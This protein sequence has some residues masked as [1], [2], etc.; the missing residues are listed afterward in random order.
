[1]KV[2][3][4]TPSFNRADILHQTAESIFKQTY[5][6]WEWVVTDDGSTDDTWKLLEQYAAAD[7]RVRIFKRNRGP[8][9]AC[10]CRNISVENATGEYLVFLDSDD[11]IASFCLEQRVSAMQAAPECD[12]IIFPMLMFRYEPGD[13][14]MLWNIDSPQDD[15]ERILLN[16]AVCQGT[17]TL[18]KKSSFVTIG[19]WNEQLLLWQ[20]VELHLRS[21]LQ[22]LKYKKRFDLK[23]DTFLRIS[24]ISISRTG[25]H[26]H[27]KFL[28]RLQVFRQTA[29][30]MQEKNLLQQYKP[31]LRSMF[32]DLFTNAANQRFENEIQP[33]LA[34][35]QQFGL[36][37]NQEVQ[38][39]KRYAWIRKGKLYRLPLLQRLI[40]ARIHTLSPSAAPT[41]NK[42]SYKGNI[43]F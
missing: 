4:I 43:A 12:F 6:D 9:G 33:V 27:P 25:Y 22:P 17:G 20:D 36:F 26:S 11:M 5:T 14:H 21:L 30:K 7:Q 29:E 15:I 28:S 42:V 24:E 19:M 1:M 39:M 23:P 31:G 10:T 13:M 41:L 18:W 2:S 37:N 40:F 35:Q 8:K 38:R 32:I 3:I 16:D 34:L